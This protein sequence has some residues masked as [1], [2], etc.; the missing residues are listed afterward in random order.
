MPLPRALLGVLLVLALAGCASVAASQPQRLLIQPRAGVTLEQLDQVLAPYGA[1]R[2]DVIR[3]INVH[4]V[5][6]PQKADARAVADALKGN[7]QIESVEIDR[8]LPPS[9]APDGSAPR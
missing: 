5:E 6:L 9:P 1:R 8:R 2:V 3:Q 4:I 7:P